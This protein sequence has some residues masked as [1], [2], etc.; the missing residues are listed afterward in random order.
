MTTSSFGLESVAELPVCVAALYQFTPFADCTLIRTD[1]L[2]VGQAQGIK[3]TLILA[4]EGINGTI[5]GSD[6][7]IEV[8]LAHIRALPGCADIEVKISRAP[9]MPFNRLKIRLKKEIV[10]MGQPGIDPLLKVGRYIPPQ[11]WNS[12]IADPDTIIIDTRNDYEVEIGTFKRAINPKTE[13]FREFPAWFRAQRARL[14]G[15]GKTPKVAMF[16]TGGIRC[17]KST[18][19]LISEGVEDVYHLQGG[20]LKYLEV[21]PADQSLWEGEC[22]VFDQRVSVGHGLVPGPYGLCHACRRPISEADRQSPLFE[23]GVSCPACHAE[24][25]EQQRS[26]YR[27]R[28]RQQQLAIQREQDH[29][30]AKPR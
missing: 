11:D 3:G 9:D 22:F 26:G 27:Q 24:R 30:G 13:N 15:E 5:A 21:V 23:D 29:I 10:T 2:A 28:H 14:L 20:I 25:T 1:L 16:C 12:L 4:Q 8:I 19:F 18:S 17:E 7:G 6:A